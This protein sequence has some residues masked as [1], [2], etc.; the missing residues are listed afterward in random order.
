[1]TP[2]LYRCYECERLLPKKDFPI[3]LSGGKWVQELCWDCTEDDEDGYVI[4]LR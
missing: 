2:K 4:Q 1:M 3:T